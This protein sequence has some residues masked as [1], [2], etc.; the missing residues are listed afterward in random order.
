MVCCAVTKFVK[1]D[2]L[3][4][5]EHP[6]LNARWIQDRIAEDPSL[7]ELGELVLKDKEWRQPH[8]GRLD[9]LFRMPKKTG[10]TK[11]R[12]NSAELTRATIAT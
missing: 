8:A 4:L 1:P 3:S 11:S 12:Y 9:P 5:K 2:R 7:L 10:G 6:E